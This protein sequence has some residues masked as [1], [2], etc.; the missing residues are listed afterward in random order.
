MK[1]FREFYEDKYGYPYPGP[2]GALLSV[3]N[4]QIYE[5]FADWAE[6]VMQRLK[7]ELERKPDA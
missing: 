4:N 5:G 7:R 2:E 6:Y 1:T 3:I